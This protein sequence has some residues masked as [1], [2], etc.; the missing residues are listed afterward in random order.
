MN[1]FKKS[2]AMRSAR[3]PQFGFSLIE[4]LVGVAIGLVLLVAVVTVFVQSRS[5]GRALEDSQSIQEGARF[6]LDRMS[7][8]LRMT[9]NAGCIRAVDKA[10]G[11]KAKASG[12]SDDFATYLTPQ[13]ISQAGALE[14]LL[15]AGAFIRA[16]NE[17]A[18]FTPVN[19]S[20][21]TLAINGASVGMNT[22]PDVL[23]VAGATA[24]FQHLDSPM[25]AVSDGTVT[26]VNRLTS[27]T[28]T[29]TRLM[30][31]SDCARGEIFNGTPTASTKVIAYDAVS[32]TSGEFRKAYGA[33]SSVSLLDARNYFVAKSNVASEFARDG[34]VLYE[35]K[36]ESA[37]GGAY[38]RFATPQP[39]VSRVT[40]FNV[41]FGVDSNGDGKVDL[42]RKPSTITDWGSA[43]TARVT[44]GIQG[45]EANAAAIAGGFTGRSEQV[46]T[47]Q[48]ELRN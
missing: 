8:A 18:G 7:F 11:L 3:R 39:V 29:N 45:S 22:P 12:A 40:R 42:Y 31:I 38:Q 24:D 47:S 6:A 43:L 23:Y 9:K 26:T 32:N 19:A 16:F 20:G 35:Q 27:G 15:G 28:T 10:I 46:F 25:V 30:I 33:N 1:R 37:P 36:L 41:E 48:V 13:V 17:G 2:S 44:L 21:R 5:T 4:L 34:W 14:K